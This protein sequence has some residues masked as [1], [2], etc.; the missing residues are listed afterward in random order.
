MS[1]EAEVTALW[2]S[3]GDNYHYEVTYTISGTILVVDE[4]S[5][6]GVTADLVIRD[7]VR[8]KCAA[9]ESDVQRI[10]NDKRIVLNEKIS[11]TAFEPKAV[12]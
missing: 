11:S 2:S 12:S 4:F 7:V 10:G 6:G 9:L 1:V 8:N 3:G 5:S